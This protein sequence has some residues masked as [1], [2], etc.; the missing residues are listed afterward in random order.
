MRMLCSRQPERRSNVVR[1]CLTCGKETIVA[2]PVGKT[3]HGCCSDNIL[4]ERVLNDWSDDPQDMSLPEYY[5]AVLAKT[6]D[7]K[8]A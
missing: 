8:P 4:C 2:G 5:A 7:V 3:T 1:K 6:C